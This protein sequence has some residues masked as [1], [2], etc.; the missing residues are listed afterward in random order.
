MQI[1]IHASPCHAFLSASKRPNTAPFPRQEA[2]EPKPTKRRSQIKIS[3]IKKLMG[4]AWSV[5]RSYLQWN[6]MTKLNLGLETFPGVRLPPPKNQQSQ[7]RTYGIHR[8]F[9]Y[10]NWDGAIG[11]ASGRVTVSPGELSWKAEPGG[12]GNTKEALGKWQINTWHAQKLHRVKMLLRKAVH[13][14]GKIQKHLEK[15]A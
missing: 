15:E 10:Q 1:L 5:E 9:P 6:P 4:E 11:T 2:A 12:Q 8:S 13:Q 7:G 3:F 14:K